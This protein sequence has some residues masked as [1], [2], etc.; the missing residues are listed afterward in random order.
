MISGITNLGHLAFMVYHGKFG[1]RLFVQGLTKQA[2]GKVCLIV[3]RHPARRLILG[4][5]IIEANAQQLRLTECWAT[6]RSSTPTSFSI[7]M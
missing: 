5:E 6:A 3:M 2:A 1:G 4:E 7:S